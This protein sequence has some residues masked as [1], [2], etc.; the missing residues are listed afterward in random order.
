MKKLFKIKKIGNLY[1]VYQR[2]YILFI[3]IW[4][5]GAYDLCPKYWFD[6]KEE[7][8]KAILNLIVKYDDTED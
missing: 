1:K 5:T 6:T 3:P 8:E 4:D 7:A 2:Y